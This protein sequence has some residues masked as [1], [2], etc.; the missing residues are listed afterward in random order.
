MNYNHNKSICNAYKIHY[1]YFDW[2]FDLKEANFDTKSST[3]QTLT[4]AEDRSDNIVLSIQNSN[5]D[6]PTSS[7]LENNRY[8]TYKN[9]ASTLFDCNQ[10]LCN[11]NQTLPNLEVEPS[12][13]FAKTS[14]FYAL[15]FL[16]IGNKQ[17]KIF[18]S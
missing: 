13:S 10:T 3:V 2:N 11:N 12:I 5:E 7:G 17:I 18:Y 15:I 8:T 4:N 16:I 6:N 9:D 14:G 1:I